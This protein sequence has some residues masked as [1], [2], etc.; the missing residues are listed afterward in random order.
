MPG[1]VDGNRERLGH[2]AG[3]DPRQAG[4]AR[5]LL[6]ERH[7]I[8]ASRVDCGPGPDPVS[9]QPEQ[10]RGATARDEPRPRGARRGA[11]DT[12]AAGAARPRLDPSALRAVVASGINLGASAG[13][14]LPAD[15]RRPIEVRDA[16]RS[17]GACRGAHAA[18]RCRA[19]ER[20]PDAA[21]ILAEEDLGAILGPGHGDSR[22]VGRQRELTDVGR[23][24]RYAR[25]SRAAG[26]ERQPR[27]VSELL[28]VDVRGSARVVEPGDDGPPG[29]VDED[30]RVGRARL[31]DASDAE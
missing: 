3:G 24:A 17:A 1:L 16:R 5:E 19:R 12:V 11:R 15:D 28:G 23:R 21:V 13:G 4:I 25:A 8:P 30:R 31:A 2:G 10:V 7:T 20:R 26:S 29:G 6:Q 27:A 14:L 9:V 22:P 18:T